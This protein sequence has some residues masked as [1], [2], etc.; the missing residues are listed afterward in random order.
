MRLAAL[1]I[2]VLLAACKREPTFD[3]RYDTA[4]K[5]IRDTA[6]EIDAELGKVPPTGVPS[7]APSQ[8][9]KT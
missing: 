7:I 9:P 2:I 5:Q 6:K 4:E 8:S 1:M 3:E